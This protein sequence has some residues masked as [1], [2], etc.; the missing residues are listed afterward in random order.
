MMTLARDDGFPHQQHE[1]LFPTC[2]GCHAGVAAGDSARMVSISP[3]ECANCHDGTDLSRVSWSSPR[4][5]PSNLDFSHPGHSGEIEREGRQSLACVDCHR[6][7]GVEA[8]MAVGGPVPSTCLDCHAPDAEEHY[9]YSQIRC[10]ECHLPLARATALPVSRIAEFPEPRTHATADFVLAHG[11][12]ASSDIS[13][14]AVCHTRD[15]C[16]RC[17][18]DAEDVSVIVGLA[19]DPRVASVVAGKPGAWPEPAS[20]QSENWIVA[21]QEEARSDVTT[22]ATCHTR[23]SCETCHGVGR[24]TVASR[25]PTA[26]PGGPTGV[27]IS[28]TQMVA[29]G[30]TSTFFDRHGTAAAIGVPQCSNC[31]AEKECFACH[32][33]VRKPGFHALDFVVRHG[34]EA[35]AARTECA[36]CHSR[37][38]FCRDCHSTLSVAAQGRSGTAFHDAQPDWLLAH[39][40]AARQNM[41]ACVGCHQERTCLRCHSA[42]S[43]FRVSPHGPDFDP[44]HVADKSTQSCAICHFSL[45]GAPG[46]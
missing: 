16:E 7:P 17:H 2:E 40:Q 46:P 38:A 33:G 41:E 45:P 18:L 6:E 21:H 44:D 27:T 26:R 30:H 37:E 31:H 10:S 14:C 29:V 19:E 35:S 32:D 1:G 20:H 28:R 4:F 36:A 9:A 22:C 3:S 25:L 15:S 42:K 23:N 8:R 12:S 34:A 13:G 43:G 24:P 39:G 5:E 11:E